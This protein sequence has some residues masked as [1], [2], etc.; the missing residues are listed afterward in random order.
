MSATFWYPPYECAWTKASEMRV[1]VVPELAKP[2]IAQFYQ[3][4]SLDD[5][6]R[7]AA[8]QIGKQNQSRSEQA[9]WSQLVMKLSE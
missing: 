6:E 7:D 9:R 3:A 8:E 4:D 2:E 5:L 1:E